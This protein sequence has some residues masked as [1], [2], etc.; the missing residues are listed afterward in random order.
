MTITEV[1][2]GNAAPEGTSQ[3]S[4]KDDLSKDVVDSKQSNDPERLYVTDPGSYEFVI[5]LK[6]KDKVQ[7]ERP[8]GPPQTYIKYDLVGNEKKYVRFTPFQ[9]REFLTAL[10]PLLKDVSDDKHK[11]FVKL[12][13]KKVTVSK[14]AYTFWVELK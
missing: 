2:A 14:T 8:D 13:V 4:W 10:E 12:V 9:Y 1:S 7:F 5:D 6:S 3:L 11:V